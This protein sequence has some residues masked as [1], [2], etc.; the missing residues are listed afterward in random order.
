MQFILNIN[1]NFKF[2]KVLKK[3]LYQKIDNCLKLYNVRNK[4]KQ[5]FE[6]FFIFRKTCNI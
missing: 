1:F 5:C 2:V 6:N 4:K 3:F